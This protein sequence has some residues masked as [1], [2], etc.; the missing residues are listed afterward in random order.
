M[1][2]GFE[3]EAIAVVKPNEEGQPRIDH[4]E[5]TIRPRLA[6]RNPR[7][8]RC[9]EGFEKY[10]TVTSSVSKGWACKS[11]WIGRSGPRETGRTIRQSS[12]S[13]TLRPT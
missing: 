2:W 13:G 4:V 1:F 12:D 5:V 10:C 6:E 9:E 3:T 7:T 11:R 8:K